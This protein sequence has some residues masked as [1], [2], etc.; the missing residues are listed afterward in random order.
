MHGRIH[1]DRTDFEVGMLFDSILDL[2]LMGSIDYRKMYSFMRIGA[3]SD[4]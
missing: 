4:T 1:A 3:Q 2:A